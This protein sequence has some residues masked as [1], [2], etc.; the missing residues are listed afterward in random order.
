MRVERLWK[1]E[2][3]E[4]RKKERGVEREKGV[5]ERWKGKEV[6]REERKKESEGERGKKE[7]MGENLKVMEG[8][9]I[10]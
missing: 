5:K 10:V 3:K 7:R 6:D 1:G 4:G 8:R 2:R 9:E